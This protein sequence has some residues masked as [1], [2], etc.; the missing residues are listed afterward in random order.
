MASPLEIEKQE[1]AKMA[2]DKRPDYP[3][4]CILTPNII[5]RIRSDQEVWD[6]NHPEEKE[7]SQKDYSC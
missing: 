6:R 3:K 1:T 7:E 5:A 4:G 2:N